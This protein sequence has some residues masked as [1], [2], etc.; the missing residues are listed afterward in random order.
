[1]PPPAMETINHSDFNIDT[2]QLRCQVKSI[3]GVGFVKL[4]PSF[5]IMLLV[6]L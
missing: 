2:S 4:C 1:M 5:D 3:L 6:K